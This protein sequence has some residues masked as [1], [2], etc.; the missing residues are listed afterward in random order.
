MP[1]VKPVS[2]GEWGQLSGPG[3]RI[4]FTRA[5]GVSYLGCLWG[6]TRWWAGLQ[7][8]GWR[9]RRLRWQKGRVC[10]SVRL[11]ELE[12]GGVL[13]GIWFRGEGPSSTQ[14]M[15]SL[16]QAGQLSRLILKEMVIKVGFRFIGFVSIFDWG[17]FFPW[18]STLDP[19]FSRFLKHVAQHLKCRVW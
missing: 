1:E 2:S 19:L 11:G 7:R 4:V 14:H 13:R 8:V 9:E 6:E 10:S 5:A 17:N 3:S 18:P 15:P 16:S 12:W